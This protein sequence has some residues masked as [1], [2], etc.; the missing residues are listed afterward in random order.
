MILVVGSASDTVASA[1][2]RQLRETGHPFQ[3]LD[4][5][6]PERYSVQPDRVAGRPGYR[7]LGGGCDGASP[8]GSIFLRHAVAGRLDPGRVASLG[9]LHEQLNRMLAVARCPTVNLPANAG[10]NYSKPF[11]VGLMAEAGFDVPRS[12]V[13]NIPENA[14][15]FYDE[16]GGRVIFKGIS[17][18]ATFAQVL[19]PD[20]LDRLDR[21]PDCPTLFQEYVA[22]VDYRVHVVGDEAFVTRLRSRGEDYRRDARAGDPD[23]IIEPASMDE[24]TVAR[25]IEITRRLGLVVSGIDFKE[26]P[27]GRLVAL[28]VNP[29]PQF[30]FYEGRSGQPITRA[31]V[32]YLTRHPTDSSNVFA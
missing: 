9:K 28:E 13:T 2:V 4:E 1:L 3:V 7:V 5:D 26:S 15:R 31:V 29:Y 16:L 22:G 19:T 6:H 24:R 18:V 21:L 23:L 17:N 14:R 10:S 27:E 8:V 20:K 30:T 32:S 25:C 11:Q 12:L